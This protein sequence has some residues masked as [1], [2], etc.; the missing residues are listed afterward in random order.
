MRVE[1]GGDD[2]WCETHS[3][4][5][6]FGRGISTELLIIQNSQENIVSTA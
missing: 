4:T 2:S 6:S 3:T 5:A 1:E